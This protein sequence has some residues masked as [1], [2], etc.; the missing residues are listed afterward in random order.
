[1]VLGH[2]GAMDHYE[3]RAVGDIVNTAARIQELNKLFHSRILVSGEVLTGVGGFL[4]RRL[5][6]FVLAGKSKPVVIYELI[7][8]EADA[9]A[10][11][12]SGAALFAEG[13]AAY[14]RR[15]WLEAATA[16]DACLSETGDDEA[17]RFYLNA[18][19]EC[20]ARHP[21]EPWEPVFRMRGK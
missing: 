1:M 13:V 14:E 7:C 20:R 6:T 8:R 21:D 18:C 11:E 19:A 10:Q 12:R 9:T 16:F 15:S 5:G 4:T 3:Y 17:A 2:V